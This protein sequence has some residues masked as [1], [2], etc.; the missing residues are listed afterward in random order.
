MD[1]AI[2][3]VMKRTD[4]RDK[5]FRVAQYT[6]VAARAFAPRRESGPAA[7]L[8]N[9]AAALGAA[10]STTRKAL[11]LARMLEEWQVIKASARRGRA[12]DPVVWYGFGPGLGLWLVD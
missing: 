3:R 8:A 11:R 6:C 5:A 10:M 1:E 2:V 4:G 12:G 9:V 7:E